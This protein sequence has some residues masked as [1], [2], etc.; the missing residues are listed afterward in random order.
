MYNVGGHT[1]YYNGPRYTGWIEDAP[2][3]CY[4]GIIQ[5]TENR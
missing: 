1:P 2:V 3:F 4:R 5:I